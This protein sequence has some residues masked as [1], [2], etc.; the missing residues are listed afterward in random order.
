MWPRVIE[1]EIG[2]ALCAMFGARKDF[3]Y[4][5]KPFPY[6][7]SLNTDRACSILGTWTR[8]EVWSGTSNFPIARVAVEP[9]LSALGETWEGDSGDQHDSFS[10]RAEESL[11]M[12]D[13]LWFEKYFP[14]HS[15][16]CRLERIWLQLGLGQRPVWWLSRPTDGPLRDQ[17]NSGSSCGGQMFYFW[18]IC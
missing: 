1:T 6:A 4:K 18:S 11:I 5:Q 12:K 7:L 10:L 17:R 15:A 3:N 2:A 13:S 8:L 16:A 9:T 14:C